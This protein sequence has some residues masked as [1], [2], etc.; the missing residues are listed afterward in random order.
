MEEEAERKNKIELI[1]AVDAFIV[2]TVT[3]SL[4]SAEKLFQTIERSLL[5]VTF[6][7]RLCLLIL[8]YYLLSGLF[9][10]RFLQH[11][12]SYVNKL[13]PIPLFT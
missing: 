4:D 2:L 13:D 3:A 1:V 12:K 5:I 11:I 7:V 8:S 6:L 10:Q 9:L